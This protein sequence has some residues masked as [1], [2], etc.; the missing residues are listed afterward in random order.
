MNRLP[1]RKVMSK[2][3]HLKRSL[4]CK[5]H[6]NADF[7]LSSSTKLRIMCLNGSRTDPVDFTHSMLCNHLNNHRGITDDTYSVICIVY[8]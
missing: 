3:F 1:S 2:R 7:L 8:M 6:D 5:P 4:S